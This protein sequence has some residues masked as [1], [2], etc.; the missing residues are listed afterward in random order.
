MLY[1]I[2]A[3]DLEMFILRSPENRL[4][5]ML[6]E[7]STVFWKRLVLVVGSDQGRGGGGGVGGGGVGGTKKRNR[8]LTFHYVVR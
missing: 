3:D 2:Q 8:E 6:L 5:F 1:K 4:T 7:T